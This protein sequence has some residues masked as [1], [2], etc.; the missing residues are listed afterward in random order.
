MTPEKPP[1]KVNYYNEFDRK[2]AAWLRELIKMGAIPNG[3][4]DERSIVDVSASD[5]HGYTQRHF[6]A[7]IGG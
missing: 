2:T 5:L 1:P 7:G 3:D 4:V 6:F